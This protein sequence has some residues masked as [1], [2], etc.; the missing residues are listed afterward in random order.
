V[1]CTFLSVGKNL[2]FLL[3]FDQVMHPT[4]SPQNKQTYDLGKGESKFDL[5]APDILITRL[6]MCRKT[7]ILGHN[8]HNRPWTFGKGYTGVVCL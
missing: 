3:A 2:I 4:F 8:D 1:P 5:V 7:A 6:K